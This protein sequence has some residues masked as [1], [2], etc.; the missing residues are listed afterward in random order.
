[1]KKFIKIESEVEYTDTKSLYINVECITEWIV[2]KEGKVD[3]VAAISSNIPNNTTSILKT[4]YSEEKF[5][6]LLEGSFVDPTF[7]MHGSKCGDINFITTKGNK[8][9]ITST[10]E[11]PKNFIQRLFRW[12]C[13]IK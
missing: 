7:H 2:N 6:E 9:D 11:Y 1:M 10:W 12:L 5:I 13:G 4:N 8:L 3:V